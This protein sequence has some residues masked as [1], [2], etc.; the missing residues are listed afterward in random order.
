M[1]PLS[2]NTIRSMF[3]EFFQEKD[4]LILPSFSLI[5]K[6]DPSIL[7]INAGMTPMKNWF[8]GATTPPSKRVATCQKCI[9]TPDIENVGISDRH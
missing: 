4:H 3:L 5:P 1:K 6:D 2:L 7:L 9:R 8:T